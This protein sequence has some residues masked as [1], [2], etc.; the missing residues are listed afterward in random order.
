MSKKKAKAKDKR[1]PHWRPRKE[2]RVALEQGDLTPAAKKMNQVVDQ[3]FRATDTH[4][5]ATERYK[6]RMLKIYNKLGA[7][8]RGVTVASADG[9]RRVIFSKKNVVVGNQN[10]HMARNLINEYVAEM[11]QRKNL[12]SDE[13]QMGEFLA[14][15]IVEAKG[16]I[17]MTR[18]LV[19]FGRMKFEDKRLRDAQRLLRDGFD[20]TE[21]KLYFYCE[22]LDSEG[23][24]ARH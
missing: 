23:N 1:A 21:S 22:E 19:S 3:A 16:R 7:G 24:W 4:A 17:M 6:E 8:E 11:L 18:N 2:D 20:V 9:T 5:V 12:S 14:G 10:A 15:V 13:M